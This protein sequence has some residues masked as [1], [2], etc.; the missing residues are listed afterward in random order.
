MKSY[1]LKVIKVNSRN[2]V[3]FM[4]K[5][6]NIAQFYLSSFAPIEKR[7]LCIVS[8]KFKTRLLYGKRSRLHA[9]IRYI[10]TIKISK[11]ARRS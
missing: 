10:R 3:F 1:I 11:I 6:Y 5:V 8:L 2:K 4:D 9:N 7:E